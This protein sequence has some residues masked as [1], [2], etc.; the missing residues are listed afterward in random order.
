MRHIERLKQKVLKRP[1]SPARQ[2]SDRSSSS[3]QSAGPAE[4]DQPSTTQKYG[5]FE[6]ELHQSQPKPPGPE[7]FP[8]DII[9]IHG[10]SGDAYKTWT[11]PVTKKLWLRDFIPEFL[12]GCRVYTFGYPSK[13]KDVDTQARV[14]EFGRK[15]IVDRAS[16]ELGISNEDSIPLWEDHKTISRFGSDTSPS[17]LDVARALRRIARKPP[18]ISPVPRRTSTHSSNRIY[19]DVETTCVK[20]L[21]DFNVGQYEQRPPK[22]IAGT[23]QWIRAHQSF[24]SWIEDGRNTLLWLTGDPGCGKTILSYSLAQYLSE[25][26]ERS[27]TILVYFCQN[28]NKQTDARAVLT[29]LI[30]QSIDRH[31]SMID[32]VRKIYDLQRQSM[33]HSF[34][35]LWNLFLKILQDPKSGAVYV[36]VDALDECEQASCRQLLESISDLLSNF[37]YSIHHGVRVK[38]LLT[39]RPFLHQSYAASKQALQPQISID[40]NQP[41]YVDDI[42]KFIQ[43]RVDEISQNRQFPRHIRDYLY[44]S[45]ML[46]ADRTFLWIQ[47]VL[48][49]LEKSLLTSKSDLQDIITSIPEDLANTY[50]RYLATIPT[51]HQDDASCLLKL[52][53]ASSRPLHLDEL[54]IAFTLKTSHNSAE[55]V[56]KDTQNAISHT[57]QGILGPLIRVSA[58]QVS[59]IHQSVKEFLL[60]QATAEHGSFPAMRTINAQSSALQLARVCIQYLLL[61]D[62]QEDFFSAEAS[63]YV[64]ETTEPLGDLPADGFT[65]SFWDNEDHDLNADILYDELGPLHSDVCE[66]L[67]ARYPFYTYASLHWAEH[68]AICEDIIPSDVRAAAKSLLDVGTAYCRNW[69]CFYRTRTATSLDDDVFGH[70]P[71]VLASQFNSDTILQELLVS[72]KPSQATKDRS[73]YWASR[74]GHNRIV[75]SMLRAGANPNS[76]GLERQTALTTAA[77]QGNLACVST[78]LADEQTDVNLPGRNGRTALSFAC[79]GGY[80]EIVN[81]LLNQRTCYVDEPD[82]SGATPF[83]W[84]V[85]GGHHSTI[86]ILIRRA[87]VDINHRDKLGRTAVSWAA[88]DGMPE[89]LTNLLK[90]PR[91]DVNITDNKGRSPLSWAAG[92]GWANTVDLLLRSAAVDIGSSDNDKRNAISWA[93]AGG[94][95][96]VVV[97]L[98]DRNCPGVD[99]EDIDGWTPLAWAIQRDSPD[100]VQALIDSRQVQIDKRDRGGRTVL[101]WAIGYGHTRVIDVLLRAGAE[102]EA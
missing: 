46:K 1:D 52:L 30:L 100:T 5:L 24:V 17:Y 59:L 49:S 55:E 91:L 18:T 75:T 88:G 33:M 77:E 65:A 43:E 95:H 93:S 67:A 62:F 61:D 15:L 21:S 4:P 66:S 32:H 76:R 101:S 89:V 60:K 45:M 84:A 102:P 44:Q 90:L 79:S 96:D 35:L 8:V 73:L 97:K 31:R 99:A 71:I 87:K 3:T 16:A 85:G 39:S 22:P 78:L 83:F 23:C 98:L 57:V 40:D 25:L 12:P 19:N 28:K 38:F 7:Q 14:Q 68:F 9:A 42:Q 2:A 48:A 13:L 56:T 63:G 82:D 51:G 20:L 64:S 36:I 53:L 58:S 70:E 92:N 11:H 69:L 86:S 6:F 27:R 34:A 80:D 81:Q 26:G 54:N 29:G 50:M 47:V 37:S 10:L 74:L 72:Y 41:G 94:H